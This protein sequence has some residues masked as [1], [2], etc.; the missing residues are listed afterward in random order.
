MIN[1]YP[2]LKRLVKLISACKAIVL[3]LCL[4]TFFSPEQSFA[5]TVTSWKGT[6]S[7]GWFTAG[8]WTNGVPRLLRM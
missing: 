2:P 3:V 6:N 8:N 4:C 5:Q 1:I 7:N